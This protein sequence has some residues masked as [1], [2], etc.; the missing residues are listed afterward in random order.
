VITKL[1]F[2]T[3]LTLAAA[4]GVATSAAADPSA[5]SVLSCSCEHVATAVDGAPA[6]RDQIALGIQTGLSDLQGVP[7]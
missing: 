7:D 6:I 1:T 5:F 2:G 3:A 4:V